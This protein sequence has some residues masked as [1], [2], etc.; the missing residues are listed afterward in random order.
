[1]ALEGLRCS[2]FFADTSHPHDFFG[3]L[4]NL[5]GTRCGAALPSI[6]IRPSFHAAASDAG[7]PRGTETALPG[8][9]LADEAQRQCE[10]LFAFFADQ[11]DHGTRRPHLSRFLG[12]SSQEAGA[13]ARTANAP[14]PSAGARPMKSCAAHW[15]D[16]P[17]KE[18]RKLP[19][20]S[21]FGN[22]PPPCTANMWLVQL[23]T[24]IP[25]HF[26]ASDAGRC[27]R[28]AGGRAIS[29]RFCQTGD[30]EKFCAAAKACLFDPRELFLPRWRRQLG[31]AAMGAINCL[32]ARGSGKFLPARWADFRQHGRHR[33][34][35]A[36]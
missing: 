20:V 2:A 9:P 19:R 6:M 35:A 14:G 16:T 33:F 22:R 21:P 24:P 13:L 32:L 23:A 4:P 15:A 18:R 8:A 34:G 31:V 3:E 28:S 29:P 5:R 7:T 25:M 1:M 11:V 12:L 10:R 26:S 36:F 30:K 27:P 17:H